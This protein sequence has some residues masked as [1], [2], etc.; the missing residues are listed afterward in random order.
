MSERMKL[1]KKAVLTSV[2]AGTNVERVKT[3]L[4]EAVQDLMKVGQTL[5]D[6][7][8][9]KGKVKTNSAQDFLKNLQS[10]A[11]KKTG[12]VEKKVSS[13]VTV[14]MKKAIR[15]LG[16]ITQEDWDELY[17]RLASIEEALGV[18]SGDSNGSGE[19]PRPRRKKNQG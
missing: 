15:E 18:A 9:E 2:G 16:L 10:E 8:E 12:E 19:K 5:M 3:A 13:K 1:L 17:E 7:L 11:L 4:N 14:G 6:E